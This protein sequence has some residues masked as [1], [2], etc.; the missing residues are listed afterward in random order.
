MEQSKN[1]ENM[2]KVL[3]LVLLAVLALNKFVDIFRAKRVK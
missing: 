3:G 2:K 1:Y